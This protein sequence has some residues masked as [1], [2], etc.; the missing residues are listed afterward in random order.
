MAN[1]VRGVAEFDEPGFAATT[2]EDLGLD[3]RPTADSFVRCDGSGNG[4]DYL[5]LGDGD[6]GFGQEITGLVFVDFHRSGVSIHSL[7]FALE[8]HALE[9]K[10][11]VAPTRILG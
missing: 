5:G 4:F 11:P 2:G 1:F 10:P 6:T 8:I 3:H 9:D 7:P